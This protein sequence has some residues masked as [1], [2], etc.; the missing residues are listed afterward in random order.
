MIG[1]QKTIK[2]E[3]ALSGIGLHTGQTVHLKF[4]PA[5]EN[6]GINFIRMD[7]PDRPVIKAEP[8]SICLNSRV[9][10]CTSL[11]CGD[12]VIYTVEHLMSAL[13][14]LGITNL[15]VEMDAL[16]L[17]GLD[18]SSLDFLKAFQKAGIIK[19]GASLEFFKI[20]EPIGVAEGGSAIYVI[21]TDEFNVSYALHYDHPLLRSQFFSAM[22]DESSYEKEIAP[23]RTFCLE[24]EADELRIQGLGKGANYQNTLVVGVN[25]VQQNELRF[26]N[27]FVRH[28]VLDLIGD[29]Y[30]LGVPILGHVFATKSGHK[31][32][33]RLL[34]KI[35]QQK[36]KFEFKNNFLSFKGEP[37][38]KEYNINQIMKM[39]P[40][41]YPFLLV[42]R[43]F[44][45]EKGRRGV[46]IKNVTINDN[47]FRGH[48]PS[49][50][51]MPGVLMVEA[52]AQTAGL[53][54][55]NSDVHRGK[56]ALFLSAD[57]V[58]FRKVVGPGDQLVMEVEVLKDKAKAAQIHGQAKVDGEIV[59]EVDM[60]FS[61]VDASYLS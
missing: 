23:S 61:F 28:K 26:E 16:E 25:G 49:R 6:T 10:R 55:I 39:L 5:S 13:C 33:H 17:P 31:L 57:N 40:H 38:Q 58:K 46:G 12:A 19:Q 9:P 30:L 3:I 52:M 60:V 34:K 1:Q 11:G 56:V 41:R 48:F 15:T 42:D 59:A 14:G 21:P 18:G 53:I 22:V 20:T 32:N 54:I 37:N 8:N 7:L 51:I 44:E 27:E 50:P 2:E 45:I 4:K 35:Y 29:L 43:I 24:S 47:F 36:Q